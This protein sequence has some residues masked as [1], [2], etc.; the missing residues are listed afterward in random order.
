MAKI[1]NNLFSSIFYRQGGSSTTF[2]Y[3]ACWEDQYS[4]LDTLDVKIHPLLMSWA[5]KVG[6]K[7]MLVTDRQRKDRE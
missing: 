1:W 2:K 5:T 4:F 6:Y 3:P 7:K